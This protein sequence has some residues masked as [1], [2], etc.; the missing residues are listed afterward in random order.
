MHHILN[1]IAKSRDKRYDN[2][3]IE[4]RTNIVDFK[5]SGY[6]LTQEYAVPDRMEI[7]KI[8]MPVIKFNLAGRDPARSNLFKS[9]AREGH[10][11]SQGISNVYKIHLV[12]PSSPP[13]Y[14]L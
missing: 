13:Q 3:E 14:H 10:L 12:A 7:I 5:Y 4:F 8:E 6:Q 1:Q 9:I 11:E 2:N